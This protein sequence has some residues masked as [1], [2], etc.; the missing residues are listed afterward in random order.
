MDLPGP[1]DDILKH[2]RKVDFSKSN[3]KTPV[4][5]FETTIRY[6]GGLI[7]GYDLLTELD[8]KKKLVRDVRDINS[9]VISR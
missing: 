2:I 8:E 3:T 4:S 9:I 7:S 5:L 6:L 1:V